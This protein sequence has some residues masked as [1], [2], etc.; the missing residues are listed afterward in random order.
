MAKLS[1]CR[2]VFNTRELSLKASG[3]HAS[4]TPGDFS[5]PFGREDWQQSHRGFKDFSLS[6]QREEASG[7]GAM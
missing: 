1:S 3:P 4:T 6:R 5:I 2:M 7:M